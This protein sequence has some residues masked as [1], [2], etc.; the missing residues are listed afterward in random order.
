MVAPSPTAPHP[1]PAQEPH[2]HQKH[3]RMRLF[4]NS[5]WRG[6]SLKCQ[7]GNRQRRAHHTNKHTKS[8]VFFCIFGLRNPKTYKISCIFCIFGISGGWSL[9][10]AKAGDRNGERTTPKNIQ[11]NLYF[12]CF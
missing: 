11:H 5:S 6:E 10:R 7:G 2:T 4:L 12:W 1:H 3:I 8:F 9:R